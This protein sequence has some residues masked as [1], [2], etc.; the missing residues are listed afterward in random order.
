MEKALAL[1]KPYAIPKG[2]TSKI[3]ALIEEEGIE[4]VASIKRNITLQQAEQFY[5]C[6]DHADHTKMVRQLMHESC[7]TSPE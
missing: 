3:R 2:H 6:T 4:I 7:N 1:L 5:A